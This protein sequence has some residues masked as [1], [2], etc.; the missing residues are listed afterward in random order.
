MKDTEPCRKT[1]PNIALALGGGVARGFAHI[2]V[3]RA[4]KKHGFI[5]DMVVGTSIGAVVGGAYLADRIDV[6]EAWALSLNRARIVSYLDFKLNSGG[7]IAGKR[8][9]RLLE[10]HLADLEIR[11]LDRRFVAVAT[12]L[13]TG[14]EIW[15]REGR[16]KDALRA[17]FSLPGIFPPIKIK[18]QFLIDGA[19]VNPV[20]VSVCRAYNPK[21]IIAVDLN[22][23]LISRNLDEIE[24]IPRAAGFD[25]Q[26]VPKSSLKSR[27]N[28][29]TKNIFSRQKNAPSIFGVMVSS[30][31]IVLDRTTR[32]RMAG[33]PPDIHIK[34]RIGHIGLME[35]DKAQE[36]ILEGEE[37]V[38]RMLPELYAAKDALLQN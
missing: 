20:P 12:D 3:I 14:H 35:F 34:P 2:G 25:I 23:D 29:F 21:M 15:L 32:S 27:M 1:Q 33:D 6:L 18:K 17:S 11:D 30:L 38:E 19:L 10:E 13:T 26:D 9:T 37:A 16:L 7:L 22:A 4:L 31:G 8:L 5:P 24:K 28:I 36:L